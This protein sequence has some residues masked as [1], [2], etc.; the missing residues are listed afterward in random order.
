M[1]RLLLQINLIRFI[2]VIILVFFCSLNAIGQ[3]SEFNASWVDVGAEVQ[4]YPA[5]FIT[6]ARVMRGISPHGNFLFRLGHNFAQRQNFGEHESE[7]GGGF[8]ISIG[9]RYYFNPAPKGFFV[10]ARTGLWL[11]NIEWKDAINTSLEKKGN[12]NILVVQPTLAAG[13]QYVTNSKKWAL[14]ASVAFGIEWNV[15]TNGEEVGQGGISI[16]FVSLT[17]RLNK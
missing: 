11:M 10:A 13:Y 17:R 8:G 4:F 1:H 12:T 5:G 6:S 16:L 14:G 3:E 2:A 9:Y 7:T 15:V